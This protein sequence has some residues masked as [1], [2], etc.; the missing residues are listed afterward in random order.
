L[1]RKMLLHRRSEIRNVEET[2][3]MVCCP[4]SNYDCPARFG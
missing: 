2:R 3:F 4:A 1:R